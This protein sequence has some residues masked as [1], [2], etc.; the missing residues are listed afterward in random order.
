M[1]LLDTDHV[2]LLK[3]AEGER[4]ARLVQRLQGLPPDEV[5]AVP[6]IAVEEQMRGWLAAIG[7]PPGF[8]ASA[9]PPRRELAGLDVDS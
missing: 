7:E 3:Y 4:G 2:T 6:V 8:R 9:G 1:I 5:L